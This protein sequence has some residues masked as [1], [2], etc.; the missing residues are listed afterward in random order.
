MPSPSSRAPATFD[1][2]LLRSFVAVVDAGS[3]AAGGTRLGRTQS[4]VTQQIQRLELQAGLPLFQKEGRQKLL[5]DPG[6]QLLRYAREMLALNDEAV[7]TLA[8]S[9]L[10]GSLRIGPPHDV[11]DTLL[12][13]L[14]GRIARDRPTPEAL[15]ASP[16]RGRRQWPG[17]AGSTASAGSFYISAMRKN[18]MNADVSGQGVRCGPACR[19]LQINHLRTP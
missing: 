12:P 13:G 3:F 15:R 16:S 7:H 17:K 10:R 14:L 4:A 9:G 2:E 18:V 8:D 5:T 11:A 6:R 1:L 19:A